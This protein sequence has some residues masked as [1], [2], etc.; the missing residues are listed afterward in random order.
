MPNC[1]L[2]RAA[3]GEEQE[4]P[5]ELTVGRTC[6]AMDC[7]WDDGRRRHG[8]GRDEGIRIGERGPWDSN[9][10]FDDLSRVKI[11]I[12]VAVFPSLVDSRPPG[13][14]GSEIWPQKTQVVRAHME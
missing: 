9:C 13:R 4:R 5:E 10:P 6:W 7:G 12:A 1:D 2:G 3:K 8:C 11:G 14:R